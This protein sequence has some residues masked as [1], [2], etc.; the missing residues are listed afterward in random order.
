M[1]FFLQLVIIYVPQIILDSGFLT[2]K[3]V[4]MIR[5]LTITNCRQPHGTARKSRSTITRHQEDKLSK[6]TSSLFHI[7]MI[8][9]LEWTYSNVKQNIEQLQTPTMGV[10]IN[11]KSTTEPPP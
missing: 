11:K 2:Y 3:I 9:I 6:A 8:A 4:S 10:T 7:Q 5:K 1:C